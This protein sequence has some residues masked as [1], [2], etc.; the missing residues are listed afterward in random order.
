MILYH[1]STVSV[2][3]PHILESVSLLDF[4]AGFY[5]TQSYEQAERWPRVKMRRAKAERGFVSVY[6]FDEQQALQA[7]MIRRFDRADMVWLQFVVGNRRG[8]AP[9]DASEIHIGPV[10]D[11]RY[12]PRSSCLKPAC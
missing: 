11:D 8:T 5:T 9:G 6:E 10:A 2:D 12:M 4:G 7:Q 3:A 1:G